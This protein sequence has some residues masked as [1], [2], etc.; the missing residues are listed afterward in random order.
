MVKL[1]V[2]GAA[3]EVKLADIGALEH[4]IQRILL[5]TDGSEPA[6]RA[7]QYAV[8]LAKLLGASIAAI[9]VDTGQED[10]ELP[11][12]LDSDD[13]FEGV[14]PSAKGLII[15]HRLAQ[16]NNVACSIDVVKGGIAKRIVHTAEEMGVGLIVLGDTGRSGLKRIALGSVA[17]AVVKASTIP[18]LVVK[19]D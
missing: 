19:A 13:Y 5:P 3:E 7:T 1:V 18:V 10:V 15:A 2:T 9:Y 4:S 16:A 11:E 12:E 8:M 14:H 6:V 17:E